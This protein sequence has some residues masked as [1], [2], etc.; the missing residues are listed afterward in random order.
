MGEAAGIDLIGVP[1]DLGVRELGLKVGPDAL[2]E[3]GLADI[4]RSLRMDVRD[5]GDVSAPDVPA[6]PGD[7][8]HQAARV[9]AWCEATARL[10]AESVRAGRVPVCLGG[11][12]S[13]SIGSVSGAA[14]V[15]GR[16]GCIWI[17]A[18]PDANTP[19]TSPSGNIHGM[20]VAVLLGHGPPPLVNVAR[21]GPKVAYA[22]MALVGVRDM[23]PGEV[24]FLQRHA[25]QM[26]TVFDI[27]ERG[28][29]ELVERT[30]R[31]AA[32]G[33]DGVHVSLDLDV[34]REDIA[35]GV[36]LPSRCG[37]DMREA[38]Y[39]CQRIAASSRVTSVDVIG[40]NPVRDV[41]META[42]RAVELLMALLGH[43]FGFSYLR[44]LKEQRSWPLRG[45]AGASP[46]PRPPATPPG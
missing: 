14:S 36:G 5:L 16:L 31:R 8:D 23:D 22:H 11:D 38:T 33:T 29:P 37:L 4:A 35:P 15:V 2:R 25:I 13:L 44:Y 27:L 34:L 3:V 7:P 18:H 46:P 20:P 43:S 26:F 12:H 1:I 21:P 24:A 30:L 40:L 39:L 42:T 32:A 6:P 45:G 41:H 17:D 28:L 10:V 19:E 9:A